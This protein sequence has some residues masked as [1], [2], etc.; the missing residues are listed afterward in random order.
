MTTVWLASPRNWSTSCAHRVIS[1]YKSLMAAANITSVSN[2]L[3]ITRHRNI[4]RFVSVEIL[5][6]N[7]LFFPL[8]TNELD[9]SVMGVRLGMTAVENTSNVGKL[10]QRNKLLSG[11]RI[12][13]RRW[14][15]TSVMQYFWGSK[16]TFNSIA[17]LIKWTLQRQT[18]GG[19]WNRA[20]V[21]WVW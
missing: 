13:F 21:D 8:L 16:T 18:G 14:L 6:F 19:F 1:P 9:T 12:C 2:S 10:H 7:W 5:L 17:S 11:M 3:L 20:W 4:P 15:C